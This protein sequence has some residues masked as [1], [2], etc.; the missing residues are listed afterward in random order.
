MKSAGGNSGVS[1]VEAKKLKSG[2]GNQSGAGKWI[3][4]SLIGTLAIF[5]VIVAVARSFLLEGNHTAQAGQMTSFRESV[6]HPASIGITSKL[7]AEGLNGFS[8]VLKAENHDNVL[9]ANII[10][11]S[12]YDADVFVFVLSEWSET[13]V[14]PSRDVFSSFYDDVRASKRQDV[15]KVFQLVSQSGKPKLLIFYRFDFSD[16]RNWP[17]LAKDIVLEIASGDLAE[18]ASHYSCSS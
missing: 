16:E 14:L 18:K 12:F 7:T 17:C 8:E 11:Q 15:K 9:D 6:G 5:F 4:P 1:Q 2:T 13:D 3:I 10:N